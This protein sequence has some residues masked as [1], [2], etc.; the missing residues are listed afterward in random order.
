MA[1]VLALGEKKLGSKDQKCGAQFTFCTVSS[2]SVE[3][4]PDTD[5]SGHRLSHVHSFHVFGTS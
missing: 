3:A 1:D 2:A 4:V 5:L